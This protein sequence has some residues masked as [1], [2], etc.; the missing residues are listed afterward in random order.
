[1]NMPLTIDVLNAKGDATASLPLSEAVFGVKP[2]SRLVHEVVTAYLANNHRGTHSTK[3]R[4]EVSGGGVKPW[5]QKHTGNARAG[6]T[7][8]PLWRHGGIIFGP[9][10]HQGYKKPV[11]R[12]KRHQALKSILSDYLKHGRL[13]VVDGFAVAEP[14]TKKV[15]DLLRALKAPAKTVLVVDQVDPVLAKASRNIGT[16]RIC[17]AKDLNGHNVLLSD[18]LLFTKTGLDALMKRLENADAAA[19]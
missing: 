14:K 9:K 11:S 7:R 15:V 12:Q 16:F 13:S 2:N 18:K 5:K 10:P 1:M 4:G 3:T 6:S 17:P 19:N 8:S